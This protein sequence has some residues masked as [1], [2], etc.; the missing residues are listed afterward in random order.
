MSVVE[1]KNKK[2]ID[3]NVTVI[4]IP[5]CCLTC[6]NKFDKGGSRGVYCSKLQQTM[7]PFNICD[8]YT[9]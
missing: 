6:K 9:P 4:D 3:A 7:K 8:H 2:V 5:S 1:F